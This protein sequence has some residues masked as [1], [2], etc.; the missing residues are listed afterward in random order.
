MAAY[1]YG[2]KTG[3]R[4]GCANVRKKKNRRLISGGTMLGQL[5]W[6]SHVI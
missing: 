6:F 5:L 2:E 3:F 4:C 1:V